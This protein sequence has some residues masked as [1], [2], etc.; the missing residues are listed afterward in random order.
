[1]R[2]KVDDI[3]LVKICGIQTVEAAQVAVEAGANFLGFMFAP[4]KRQILPEKAMHIAAT[5]PSHVKKV[6]VFVNES[7]ETII[8]IAKQVGLDMIQ[9]HGDE[10][11]EFTNTLPYETI[12]AFSIHDAHTETLQSY[13]CN[14]YIIDS[15]PTTYRGGSGETFDWNLATQLNIDPEKFIL[16]G[17]LSANNIEQAIQTVQPTGVDVSSGVETNGQKDHLK[18]KQFIAKAKG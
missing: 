18:I 13:T 10:T 1:M 2:G 15:P 6:G 9:L 11:A 14:Y 8:H 3:M 12:K 7:K 16:A 4:S 5:V 17:G